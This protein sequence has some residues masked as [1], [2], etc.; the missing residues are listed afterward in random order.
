[1]K[2]EYFKIDDKGNEL[3]ITIEKINDNHVIK[4]DGVIWVKTS[5]YVHATV[6]FNMV[7][8][9]SPKGNGLVTAQS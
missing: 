5:N 3:P 8:Y 9:P 2:T 7:N 4:T 1:M 6:L